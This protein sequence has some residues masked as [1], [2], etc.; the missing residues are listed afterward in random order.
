LISD[1]I[2]TA[3][4]GLS[5]ILVFIGLRLKKEQYINVILVLL[6]LGV[7]AGAGYEAFHRILVPEVLEADLLAFSAAVVSGLVCLLLGLYQQYVAARSK[8]LPLISQAVD[9]RNHAIVA[10][11]VTIG[12]LAALLRFPL[13]D[14]L[15]GLAIAGLI[16]K[17][18][19]ELAIETVRTLRGEEIDFSRYELAFV[20]EYNRF[21][22]QQL[23]D[24]LL[25]IVAEERSIHPSKLLSRSREMLDVK[26][27]P[28]LREMGWSK[29]L[30]G[31]E[32]RVSRAVETLIN[33]SLIVSHGE[34]LEITEKGVANLDARI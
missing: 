19:I 17:S 5:S 15:V 16:L 28:V 4:D 31:I 11:G 12:L 2:D 9:S 32:K 33:Q 29:T 13:L 10:A 23:A 30:K 27:V 22:E 24:W 26:D 8:Q 20:E 34:N 7:G 3:M 21:Q 25:S 18:G 1:G 14:S 6:M